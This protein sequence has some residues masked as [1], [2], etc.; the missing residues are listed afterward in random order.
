[1]AVSDFEKM[2][3]SSGY[4]TMGDFILKF[5]LPILI[6][7]FSFFIVTL[8]LPFLPSYTSYVVIASSIGFIFLYPLITYQKQKVNINENMHL[9]ITYAGTISTLDIGRAKLFKKLSEKKDTFKEIAK[10]ADKIFYFAKKWNLGFSKAA[11]KVSKLVA[12]DILADFLDRFAIM[13]DFGEDLKTFLMDEQDAVMDDFSAE[14]HKALKS[15]E[16]VQ[17]IFVS[18]TMMIA[19]V[20]STSLLLPLIAGYPMERVVQYSLMG[21]IVMDVF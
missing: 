10:A 19:F 16:L 5:V 1:M 7:G 12:S 4:V 8:Y 17:E 13:M 14:Y 21:V 2:V 18:L 9:M 20:M 15:I 3:L 6:T 11:R